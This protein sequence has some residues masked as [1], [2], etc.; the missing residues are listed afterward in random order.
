[1][2]TATSANCMIA[3][4]LYI[5]GVVVSVML[6]LRWMIK[7]NEEITLTDVII[8]CFLGIPSWL[9]VISIVLTHLIEIGGGIVIY[10]RKKRREENVYNMHPFSRTGKENHGGKV[11]SETD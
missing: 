4:F 11:E 7:T 5:S 8:C 1:M 10:R 6:G 3:S 9:S 2:I